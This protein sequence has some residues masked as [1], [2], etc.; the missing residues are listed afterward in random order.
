MTLRTR[1]ALFALVQ[2]KSLDQG[3]DIPLD[4]VLRDPQFVRYLNSALK[5]AWLNEPATV[6][7]NLSNDHFIHPKPEN[8]FQ[9]VYVKP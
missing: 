3:A 8:I 7:K 9:V 5:E 6:T 4:S 1:N 2:G